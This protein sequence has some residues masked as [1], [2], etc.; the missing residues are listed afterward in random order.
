MLNPKN[1]INTWDKL[2][3]KIDNT[4][5]EILNV[6]M[7]FD[8]DSDED[9]QAQILDKKLQKMRIKHENAS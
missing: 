6:A 4:A 9:K 3:V 8:Q 7:Q 1:Q 2:K 5:Q